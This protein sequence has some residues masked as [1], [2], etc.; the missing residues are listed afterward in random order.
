MVRVIQV[1]KQRN[2]IFVFAK[3]YVLLSFLNAVDVLDATVPHLVMCI[4][5]ASSLMQ[6]KIQVPGS[7]QF[8]QQQPC[9]AYFTYEL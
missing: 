6:N 3:A 9:E 5:A 8:G 7:Y 2:F 4:R 1:S